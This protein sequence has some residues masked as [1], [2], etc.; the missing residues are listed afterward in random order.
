MGVDHS[1]LDS[2]DFDEE[3]DRIGELF[4]VLGEPARCRVLAQVD[5][6]EEMLE[7]DTLAGQLGDDADAPSTVRASL[8]H[9]HLPKL[10][11]HGLVE[12]DSDALA[13]ES[14]PATEQALGLIGAASNRL[15]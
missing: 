6:A 12:Y 8:A 1:R 14:V 11:E 13:V 3:I 10:N 9:V 5:A 2:V 7:V 15:D 4:D